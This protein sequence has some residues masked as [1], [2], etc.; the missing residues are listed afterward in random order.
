MARK[1]KAGRSRDGASTSRGGIQ[2]VASPKARLPVSFRVVGDVV[3]TVNRV[4]LGTSQ[5]TTPEQRFEVAMFM[6]AFNAL[7]A[8]RLL[9]EHGHW[10]FA[11]AAVRQL[12][13][14]TVNREYIRTQPD[15]DA[16]ILQ[17]AKFGLLQEVRMAHETALY[18][19][20]AGREVDSKRVA[21]LESLLENTFP[22]FRTVKPT[23]GVVWAGSWCRQTTRELAAKS[24]RPLREAQYRLLFKAWSEQAHGSPRTL[25]EDITGRRGSLEQAIADDDTRVAETAAMAVLFFCE[26]WSLL[27]HIPPPAEAR[28]AGWMGELMDEARRLGAPPPRA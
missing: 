12:F 7:K 21:T 10:E 28:V 13:E 18:N 25:L 16:A 2:R 5:P 22:E 17:Y 26:L 24:R 6:R 11:S 23:G 4:L 15:A 19:Q 1:R 9:L 3:R 20:E 8:T 14:L 27:P